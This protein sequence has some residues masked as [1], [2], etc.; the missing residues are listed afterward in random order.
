MVLYK[1]CK[2]YGLIVASFTSL[3][4]KNVFHWILVASEAFDE[5]MTAMNSPLVLAL[6]NFSKP[7][8]IECDALGVGIGVVLMKENRPLAYLSHALKGK[9]LDLSTYENELLALVYAVRK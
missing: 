7:F 2:K 4:K 5:L 6:P 8:L 9:T 3:L 1:I